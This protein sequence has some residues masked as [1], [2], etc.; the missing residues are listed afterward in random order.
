M[1]H[2]LNTEKILNSDFIDRLI[3]FAEDYDS[4]R[5]SNCLE[6]I[7]KW[8]KDE[9]YSYIRYFLAPDESIFTF[10]IYE[11]ISLNANTFVYW[12][13]FYTKLAILLDEKRAL[14]E[15]FISFYE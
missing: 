3:G 14:Y 7:Q 10:S 5:H 8:L 13:E 15:E 2:F 1:Q 4:L 9:N 6:E 11:F 12:Q